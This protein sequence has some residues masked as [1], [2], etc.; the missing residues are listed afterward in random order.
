VSVKNE[1]SGQSIRIT[2]SIK[3]GMAAGVL[4]PKLYLSWC[5]IKI[6][7]GIYTGQ[8]YFAGFLGCRVGAFYFTWLGLYM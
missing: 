2:N 5:K 4:I 1:L 3:T 6:P 7:P 8:K